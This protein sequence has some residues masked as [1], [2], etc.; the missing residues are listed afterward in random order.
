MTSIPFNI[1]PPSKGRS[2]IRFINNKKMIYYKTEKE[3]EILK[4][5][6]KILANI[7]DKIS[8]EVNL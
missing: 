1:L 7:L 8:K 3:I 6:G 4:Q 5:G 2:G